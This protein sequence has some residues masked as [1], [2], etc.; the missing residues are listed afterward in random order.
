MLPRY[1]YCEASSPRRSP[2][3]IRGSSMVS[4]RSGIEVRMRTNACS[5]LA[6]ALYRGCDVT[7]CTDSVALY[8]YMCYRTPTWLTP[9]YKD[10]RYR[11]LE[12]TCVPSSKDRI[13]TH[14]EGSRCAI[15]TI[16]FYF[17]FSASTIQCLLTFLKIISWSYTAPSNYR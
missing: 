17:H 16:P 3:S 12:W 7:T 10:F 2:C 1:S 8:M 14:K 4:D 11:E 6:L 13:K 15:K 5:S 9:R